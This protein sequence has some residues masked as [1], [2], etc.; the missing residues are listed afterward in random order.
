[1]LMSAL[2]E[3]VLVA[4]GRY[5]RAAWTYGVSD[6]TRAAFLLVPALLL[7]A[8]VGV[9]VSGDLRGRPQV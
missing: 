2:F 7:A 3:I 5:R 8:A 6:V 1:M 4:R 9:L